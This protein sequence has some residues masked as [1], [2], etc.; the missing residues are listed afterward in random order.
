LRGKEQGV[1]GKRIAGKPEAGKC[2][3]VRSGG[4]KKE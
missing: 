4:V 2:G 1:R 3:V